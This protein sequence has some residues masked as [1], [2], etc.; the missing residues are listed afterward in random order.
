M[1]PLQAGQA[2]PAFCLPTADGGTVSLADFHGRKLVIFF[3]PKADTE[4][5]T[6]E[7]IDF[8][9]SKAAFAAVGAE[10]LG[11]SHDPIRKQQKF[12]SKHG[13]STTIASD[14]TL[15]MLNAYGV[16]GEKSMYG[17]TYLGIERTTM[18]ID[19]KGVIAQAWSKVRVANHVAE[20]LEAARALPA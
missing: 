11:V 20:V 10:L 8:S 2:A 3:Y 15:G 14:E 16:W 19:T 4:A 18:L 12:V 1:Q 9:G 7:A 5:C 6:R 17:R 13:L